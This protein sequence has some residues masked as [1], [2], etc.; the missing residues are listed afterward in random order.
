M[1]LARALKGRGEFQE[2]LNVLDV[3]EEMSADQG[4]AIRVYKEEVIKAMKEHMLSFDKAKQFCDQNQMPLEE[5]EVKDDSGK[6]GENR[7]KAQKKPTKI[8]TRNQENISKTPLMRKEK[9]SNAT[10]EQGEDWVSGCKTVESNKNCI[11]KEAFKEKRK[12]SEEGIPK[13]R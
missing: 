7:P 1:H 3:A 6:P 4:R 10:D 12:V 2:A 9:Q 13:H 8:Y 11:N 5:Q